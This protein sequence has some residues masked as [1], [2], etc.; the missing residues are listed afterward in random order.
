MRNLFAFLHPVCKICLKMEYLSKKGVRTKK[1]VCLLANRFEKWFAIGQKWFA[2]PKIFGESLCQNNSQ[3]PQ[4]WH[5]FG[6]AI[7]P[8]SNPAFIFKTQEHFTLKF[9]TDLHA[10]TVLIFTSTKNCV[11][12]TQV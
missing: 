11:N 3:L 5:A 12:S 9:Y 1:V 2:M 10:K 6:D 7:P 8:S 4:K